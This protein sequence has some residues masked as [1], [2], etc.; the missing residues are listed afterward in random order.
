MDPRRETAA[1]V[2]TAFLLTTI[3]IALCAFGIRASL[4]RLGLNGVQTLLY[5]GILETPAPASS[6]RKR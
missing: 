6:R 5:L 1:M 2:L 4:H 3:A